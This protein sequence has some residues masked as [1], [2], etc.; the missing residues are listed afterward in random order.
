LRRS[1]AP[2]H[3]SNRAGW[4]N[5]KSRANTKVQEER[6]EE[7]EGVEGGRSVVREME[8]LR[9]LGVE[10]AKRERVGFQDPMRRAGA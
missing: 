7:E 2:T 5:K 10:E 4:R 6:R 3:Q 1:L 8:R 9:A